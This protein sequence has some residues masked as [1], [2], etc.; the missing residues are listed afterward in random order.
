[1]DIPVETLLDGD[2]RSLD[3]INQ[4]LE[5]MT[6]EERVCWTMQKLPA[7]QVVSSSFGIHSAHRF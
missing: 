1:M 2:E 7:Q 6:V 4:A 3:S 5:S